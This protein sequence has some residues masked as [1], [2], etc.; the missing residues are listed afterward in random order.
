[1]KK[2]IQY[3]ILLLKLNHYKARSRKANTIE[4]TS[5]WNGK[6]A[7]TYVRVVDYIG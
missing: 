4:E 7:S 2:M 6:Y 3:R 1:M 5:Y